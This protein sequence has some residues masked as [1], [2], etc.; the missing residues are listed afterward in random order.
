M[1]MTR[2]WTRL[3]IA[4]AV[5]ASVVAGLVTGSA[6]AGPPQP[7]K[8]KG[9]K[10][11][12]PTDWMRRYHMMTLTHQRDETVH[13]GIRTPRFSLN[14]C[15]ECHQ[16]KGA[17]GKAVSVADPKHF[18]RTCHDYAAVRIDCFDCHA[19]RPGE[20]TQTGSAMDNPHTATASGDVA[21]LN[22]YLEGANQ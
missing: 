3:A 8:G 12:A 19:S 4:V 14:G 20:K 13:E 17:D 22:R 7:A 16:V 9:E 2:H 11:V 21:T 10:C 18:C 5:L 1:H 6:F 15:I